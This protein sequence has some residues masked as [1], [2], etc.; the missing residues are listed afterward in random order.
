MKLTPTTTFDI[1]TAPKRDSK[2]WAQGTTTW[3]EI[4]SWMDAPADHKECGNYVLGALKGNRRTKTSIASRG[5]LTLDVDSPDKGFLTDVAMLGYAV[6]AH[7]TFKSTPD[8]PR[9]RLLIPLDRTV[10]PDEYYTAAAAVMQQLGELQF[11]P[12]SVQAERYMF[13]PSESEPGFFQWHLYEGTVAQADDLLTEFQQ[14]LSTLPPPKL[15]RN[16]RD[17]YSIDGTVGAFN[18]AYSDWDELIETFKLPYEPAGAERWQ[19]VGATAAAGMG[20]V[21]PGLVYSH[22]ANDPA[23]GQTCSAF[24]LV[25]LHRFGHLDENV[26]DKTPVNRRPSHNSMLELATQDLKTVNDLI[27]ADFKAELDDIAD[28]VDDTSWQTR[29]TR[30]SRTGKVNDEVHNW[31][32]I[33]KYDPSFK[34]LYYNEL[35][36][37]V[38]TDTDLPWRKLQPGRE[39]FAAADR[40]SLALHIERTYGIRPARAYLDDL[41]ADRAQAR[42]INPVRAYL[43][44]LVWDGVPR[45][46]TSLPGVAPSAY[47]R[48]VARKVL[49]AAVARMLDPGC[50]WDHTLI[51]YGTEGLGKT[52]WIDKMSKGYSA[53]M[54]RIGDKDTLITMQR[55]WIMTSDEG[56]T[57]KKADFDAQ[58]EFLTRTADIFRMPYEREAQVQKRHCV[59]WGTTNDP[60]F[61]RRQEGNRRFLIVHCAEKLDFDRMTDAYVDQVWAEAL[62]L[63]RAGESLFLT[64]EENQLARDNREGFLEEDAQ[65][66]MIEGYLDTLVPEDWDSTSPESRQAWLMSGGG[67]FGQAGTARID[68]VCTL[69][70]WVEA[71]G[72]RKGDARRVDLLELGQA[73]KQVQGWVLLP[74]RQRL[75]Q[76]GPQMVYQRITEDQQQE[77]DG[78][79]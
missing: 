21:S 11:D 57:L 51:L 44:P 33:A 26:P 46:E 62:H 47:T 8:V 59:I 25:R 7:T 20:T 79:L 53:S 66:G 55:S 28:D 34:G 73:M 61:L 41:I 30:N 68:Q 64:E 12:G 54:G 27:G 63:Y 4:L 67:D 22:H 37:A 10:A 45:L 77:L 24:D 58:K 74:G 75:P 16:K 32:L 56:H 29:F 49:V 38:E 43:E 18:R 65:A 76:Y 6:L 50:K 5:V 60:V 78:L 9:Y 72:R 23:Y 17:P 3:S 70:L 48:M 1:A 42:R 15:S 69:Q 31:D 19:L 13:K 71:M 14:D 39:V 36:M 2:V 35:S 40:S 52:Y